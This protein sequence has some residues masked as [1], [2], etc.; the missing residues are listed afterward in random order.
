MP[1]TSGSGLADILPLTPLQE[2][3]FFHRLADAGGLDLYTS[4]LTLDLAGPLEPARLR[5]AGQALLDR[6]PNLR[7]AF[8]QRK[9]GAPVALIPR[10]VE[11]PWRELDL[12]GDDPDKREHELARFADEE[13]GAPFDPG[14]PPLVRFALVR[15]DADRHTLVVT[16]HHILLDGWSMPL[17]VQ[18]LCDL[19]AAGGDAGALPAPVPFRAHLEWL[20][21]QDRTAAVEEWRTVLAGVP[22]PTLVRPEG[23]GRPA[24]R[25]P[26]TVTRRLDAATTARLTAVAREHGATVSTVIQL[27]WGLTVATLTGRTDVVFGTTVAGRSPEVEGVERIL[28]LCINTVPVRVSL[29]PAG[30][31][32]EN[33]TA[34]QRTQTALLDHQHLGLPEI[35]RAAGTGELFDTMTVVE[36]WPETAPA[37]EVGGVRLTGMTCR[38]ATHYPLDLVARPDR[39]LELRVHHR[40]DLVDAGTAERVADWLV[41]ALR[42][43]AIEPDRTPA[44][45]DL[46]AAA[47]RTRVLTDWND[48]AVAPADPDATLT[49]RLAAQVVRT[50]DALAVVADSR[51]LT[52]RQLHDEAGRLAG[53]LAERGVGPESVVA[54]SVPRSAELMIALLA[55]ELA[56]AAYLPVEVDLPAARRRDLVTDARPVI[57]LT[58]RAGLDEPEALGDLDWIVLDD[59]ATAAELATRVV[60][61]PREPHPDGAAY[62][63]YTSGSTGRPK[64]VAVSH[65]AIVNRLDWMQSAMPLTGD[66][67]VLQKTPAGFDVS[68]WE[69]FW[70]LCEGAAVVFARPGGHADPAYLRELIAA[71]RVTTLHF[72]P[73]MLAAFLASDDGASAAGPDWPATLRRCVCSGEALST[74]LAQRWL[75]RTGVELHNL[76]GPT[77][78]AVD[79]TAWTC[80]PGAELPTAPGVPIGRPVW[81]TQVRVLDAWLRP[82]PVGVPGELYL[83]GVQLARGYAGRPGLTSER[84][85]ADP[86]GAPGERLYRTG[87]LV[88]WRHDG[89]LT[90]LGRTDHQVKIRGQRVEPGELEAALLARPDVA[91]AAAVPRTDGPGGTYLCAYVVPATGAELDP[92]A[93][94]AE[95]TATLPAGLVPGAVV[96][97]DALP[98]TAN[99]KLD[100]AGLPAPER[101]RGERRE[102]RTAAE[103]ALCEVFAAVLRLDEVG[104]D[105]DFFFLGGDSIISISLVAQARRRGIDLT[106]RQIFEL[107]TPAALAATVPAQAATDGTPD[108][109]PVALPAGDPDGV[110]N[111]PL[112]PVVHWLRERGGP[113]G[114]FSQSVLVHTPAG[115]DAARLE[116]ALQVLFDRHDALRLRLTRP[117]PQLWSLAAEPTGR[118]RA[119][120]VLRRVDART[121]DADALRAA[122]AAET[123]AAADRLDPEAGE[124]VA[125]VWFDR[126]A[127]AGRL[128]LVV[129]HLAVDGVS[130]RILLPDLAAAWAGEPLDA[131]PT[132]LRTWARRLADEAASPA[133][134][135]ELEH[136]TATTAPGARLVPAE[137]SAAELP[138]A[139]ANWTQADTARTITRLPVAD[140]AALL[141]AVPAAARSG[142]ANVLLVAF[143]RAVDRWRAEAGRATGPVLVDVEGHGR[144]ASALGAAE[145]DLS[146]TVGWLTTVHPLRIETGGDSL[147]G[148]V[149]RVKETVR[150]VPAAGLGHGLLR[151]VNPQSAPLLAAGERA[152]VLFNYLGRMPAADRT[153]TPWTPA[154]EAGVLGAAADP[155]QPVPYVLTLDALTEDGPDGPQLA[156]TWTFVPDALS[157]AD[158]DALSAHFAAAVA[159]LREWAAAGNTALTPADLPAVTLRQDEIDR[160][161]AFHR[162][163]TPGSTV[164]DIWPLS[165]L[166]EGLFFLASFDAGRR[167]IYTVQDHFDLDTTVDVERLRTALAALLARTPVLRAGFTNDGLAAPVQF[168]ASVVEP[169]LDVV[170]LR[171][172][173][174]DVEADRLAAVMAAD[175]ARRFDVTSPPLLAVTVVLRDGN[176]SR[177]VLSH[178]LLLWDGWSA[179]LLFA[180][181]FELYASGGDAAGLPR[182]GSYR[183]YLSWLREQDAE[184]S[185]A[186]WRDALAELDSP[187]LVHP[188]LGEA[189][190]VPPGIR[191]ITLD[192]AASDAIR[193]AARAAGVTLNTLVSAAWGLVLSGL[194]GSGDVVFGTTVSG[195]PPAVPDVETVI[196]LF[197]NTVPARVRIDPAETVTDL[198]GRLH[199]E[200]S[201]VLGHDW[202]GLARIQRESGHPQLFDTLSVMQNFL[203][204]DAD[205]EAFRR[206]HG[207]T[208]VGYADATHYPLTLVVTPTTEL[209]LGLYH[210][211]D[212]VTEAAAQAVLDRFA[213]VLEVLVADPG[214]RVGE[215]DTLTATER[216]QVLVEWNDTAADAGT[217]SISELLA[218][219]AALCPDAVALVTADGSWTYAELEA[220]VNRIARALLARGAGPER[221]VALALPRAADMVAALF[222]VLRTG[223]A[224]LPI[225]ADTPA[226]RVAF[227]LADAEP[228]CVLTTAARDGQLP[229]D[230]PEQVR[231]DDPATAAA[232]GAL[233]AEPLADAERPGFAPGVPHRLEHPAY[234]I[235]TSG[236][237]GL[238]KGVITPYRGLTNMQLN[239]RQHIFDPVVAQAGGRRLRI[240]HTVSF[241]FDMSWEELLWLVE[242]H[243]VHVCDEDLRRD[244]E[245]LVAYCAAHAVDVVNVTP[246]YAAQLFE[247]GLLDGPH[248][249]P[250]VLLGGE[251]VPEHVWSRLL[252]TPGVTGYNLYGPTEYTINTLG[253]GTDDSTTPTVGRPIRNTVAYVLD[254]RLRPVPPGVAGELYITGVGLARGYLKRA[255]LTAERFVADPFGEPGAR[256]YRTGDLVRWRSDGLLDFVGRAD[257]QVKIR[258]YRV[259]PGEVAAALAAHPEVVDAAVI[260][261]PAGDGTGSSRLVGYVVPAPAVGDSRDAAESAH[262]EQWQQIYDAEYTEI[263]TA[264]FTTDF[265][266]WDSS[267]TGA[268]IPF[269]E[270]SEWRDATL[271]R[272]RS[273]GARRVL[274]VGVGSGLLLSGLARDVDEYWATDFSAPV[275][276]KLT[277]DVATDPELAAR[278]RLE[279]RPAEHTAGLPRGH[280]DAVV[281]NS[282]VQYFPSAE[283]LAEV[284]TGLAELLAPGGTLFVG[285]VRDL[286]SLRAFHAAIAV[287]QTDPGVGPAQLEAQIDRRVAL[288]KELVLH[289]AW[290]ADLAERTPT[291]AGAD[292]RLKAGR[293]HNELTRH[294]YDVLLHAAGGPEPVAVDTVPG[295]V[296][297]ADLENPRLSGELAALESLT[298][299]STAARAALRSAPTGTEPDDVV[300]AGYRTLCVPGSEPDRYEAV[301]VPTDAPVRLT[302][303]CRA[304]PVGELANAPAAARAAAD[305]LVRLRGFLKESMPDYMVPS[306]LVPLPALPLTVN[307]KLDRRALPAPEPVATTAGRPP[308]TPVEETLCALFAEVL[309]LE[310]VGATD[311]FF[312]AGG[313]SLL[314]TR[315]ISRARSELGTDLA[316]RDLFE[317]PTAEE[318]ARRV[319]ATRGPARAALV[320]GPRPERVPLSAAQRRLWLVDRLAGPSAAYNFPLVFR[321]TGAL[322]TD[323]LRAAVVDVMTRHE[324]L[325]TLF[326]ED[327]GEPY[328]DVLDAAVAAA[329]FTRSCFEVVPVAEEAIED[330]VAERVRAPFRLG[331][332]LPVRVSVLTVAPDD[333][334]V[335]IV[336]HH[337]TTDEWSDRPFLA[338]LDT[339]YRARVAG[340]DPRLPALPV[341]YA[342]YTLWQDRLLGDAADPDSLMARQ[343]EYWTATLAGSPVELRLPTDRPRPAE[344]SGAGGL[345]R[346]E[347]P[348]ETAAGLR[349]LAAAS[350][351][352]MFMTLHAAFA[353]LLTRLGAGEDLPIGVPV[354]GRADGALDDL[355][356]FFVNTVVL[357]T[358][359]SGDPSFAD[360]LGRVRETGLAA[361]DAA[362]VPFERVVE[363]VNPPRVPGRNPLFGVLIG[364]HARSGD[365]ADLLGLPTRWLDPALGTA[366]FDLAVDVVDPGTGAADALLLKFEYSRDLFDGATVAGL[367]DRMLRLLAA[368]AA[369]P[370]RP[371]SR[372][373]LLAPGEP[374]ELLA[375]GV[376]PELAVPELT[377]AQ[378]LAVQA[379]RT[380]DRLALVAG[381]E[382]LTFA[383]LTGRAGGVAAL[384]TEHG[385]RPGDLVALALPRTATVPAIFGVLAAGAAYLPVDANQPPARL[386]QMFAEA[387][388]VVVLTTAELAGRLPAGV[389]SV[390]LPADAA[391]DRFAPVALPADAPAYVI[392]TSGS[393]G[394]P[395]GVVGIHRGLTNLFTAQRATV[396]DPA[397][398]ALGR[399]V[400]RASCVTSFSFDA[401]WDPLLWLVAGHELHVL[402]DESA[403]DPAA[404]VAYL[405]TERIDYLDLTPTFL[406][407]LMRAGLG[408]EGVRPAVLVVGGEATPP[409]LWDE[410]TSWPLV[411]VHDL[412][413]PTECTVDAWGRS[414]ART[415]DTIH[416]RAGA[417]ANLAI[418]ILDAGLAPVPDGVPGELYLAG[419][420]LARGYLNRPG[421]TADRFVADPFGRPG[422][423]MY[424]TGDL[425]RRRGNS[426][427]D[428]LG[429]VDGQ[430]KLRGLRIETGEIEAALRAAGAADAAVVVREDRPGDPRLVAYVV[431]RTDAPSDTPSDIQAL[432]AAAAATLPAALVPSAFVVLPALPRSVAGKVDRAAL[433]APVDHPRSALGRAPATALEAQVCAL[434]AEVLG[435]P[436]GERPGADADFF[437]LGGHSLLAMRLVA[438]LRAD[439][440]A[441]VSLRTVFDAPTPERLAAR[442]A[443]ASSATALSATVR[444][445]LT[446]VPAGAEV[447]LAPAQHGLW[448]LDRIAGPSP[449]Y[450]I[451]IA[452]RLTGELDAAALCAAVRDLAERHEPL[453]TVVVERDGLPYQRLVP[454]EAIRVVESAIEP[455]D[456]PARLRAAALHTF[457]LET[458]PPLRAELLR[459]GPTDHV[460]ALTVH[461]IAADEWS[462][463]PLVTDLATAYAARRAGRAPE[464]ASLPARYADF[465]AWQHALLGERGTPTEFARAQTGFWRNALIGLPVELALPTD[466][467]RPPVA[468]GRG[469][470]VPVTID[471]ELAAALRALGRAHDV[472]TFMVLQAAVA[473]LLHRSGA[474]D[475]I[476]I[477]SPI[478]G[479]ADLALGDLVGYFL[480]T[481]VLRTDLSGRPSFA[482]VLRRVRETDLAA[483]EHQDLPFD[484]VVEAVNPAR[485]PSRHPLFQVMVVH[486]PAPDGDPE[487]PGLQTTRV[488]ADAAVAKFDLSFDFV[489]ERATDGGVG[490]ISGVVEYAADL[491]DE[492]TAAGLADRLLRLLRAVVADPDRPVAGIDVL[493]RG[494]RDAALAA[495][496]GRPAG[497][498]PAGALPAGGAATVPAL[499]EAQVRRDP[500]APALVVG[501]RRLTFGE[502]NAEANRLARLLVAAGAGPERPVGLVLPRTHAMT[503]IL[504]A[505]KAGA[506]Y[507]PAEPDAPATR[508]AAMFAD[509]GAVVVVTSSGVA[510]ATGE[511][512]EV[513][514]LVVDDPATVARLAS[515][516]DR[517]L[518]DADRLAPLAP[519]HPAYVIYTSGS[520][521]TPKGV[522][523]PH[524][525]V[526]NLYASHAADLHARAVAAAGRDR[527]RVGHAWSFSFDASWQPQLWLLGG[528][529]V[530]VLDDETRRDADLLVAAV[531]ERDL[532]FLEVTPSFLAQLLAAGLVRSD[533]TGTPHCPLHLLGFGGEAVPPGVWTQLRELAGTDA[534]NL[535]GP[536][537]AT[538]DSLVAFVDESPAPVV[539]RPVAGARAC[540]LDAALHPVPPGVTGE[541]YLSGAGLARGYLNR[542]G[543]TA[544]RFVADPF[545]R[546]GTRMYRT[547]DLARFDAAGRLEYRGRSDDQVKLRGYRIEPAEIEAVLGRH[548]DLAAAVVVVRPGPGGVER[549]VAY[550]VPRPG[551]AAPPAAELR[552]LAADALPDHM[553]PTVF[554]SLDALPVLPGGKLNRAALPEPPEAERIPSRPP[555]TAVEA[556]VVLVVGDLLGIDA[557]VEDDFF[558]LGGDSILAMQVVSRLRALDWKV[559]PRQ[560]LAG[561]TLDAIAAAATPSDGSDTA[562]DGTGT[563]PL[564]PTMVW[565]SEVDTPVAAI[566]QSSL[567]LT[568]VGTTKDGLRQALAAVVLHHDL[569]RARL[570]RG[571]PWTLEVPPAEQAAVRLE[572]VDAK[573]G[574]DL[575]TLVAEHARAARDRVDPDAGVM[576]AAVWFDGGPGERGRLL[577]TVHHLVMDAMSW[578]IL[579]EDLAAAAAGRDLPPV[580]TSFR[581][582]AQLL[583]AQV[584][585]QR[586]GLPVAETVRAGGDPLPLRRPLDPARDVVG[587][588]RTHCETLPTGLTTALLGP[589][590][591]AYGARV[592]DVLLAALALAVAD[593][594]DRRGGVAS[595]GDE[596]GGTTL[597]DVKG[598]GRAGDLDVSRT[599]GRFAT[600]V[601][602]LLDP[603]PVR[604]ADV[605]S[606]PAAAAAVL[607]RVRVSAQ[608]ASAVGASAPPPLEFNYLGRVDGAEDAD[609]ASAPEEA[610]A[611][612]GLDPS[613]PLAHAL[614]LGAVAEEGPDGVVLLATW[615]WPDGVLDADAVVDLAQTWFRALAALAAAA[616][617]D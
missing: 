24:D 551:A 44:G 418:R 591:A 404:V 420:G 547:G 553:V 40:L 200:R 515:A 264:V 55:V 585:H 104:V 478:T 543:L 307:G 190:P 353:A 491:F 65:R 468:T 608:A 498:L 332:E 328:Q 272:I 247:H 369:D 192:E 234:V 107:R 80:R 165:P 390:V 266:G 538:V 158:V 92:D 187:T 22:G 516:D 490:G 354:A 183:D 397:A 528:H 48:T 414:A 610:A 471:A 370:D 13:Q 582:H 217:E 198:L 131:V 373:D 42:S 204:D 483:Y 350:G 314:A 215:L 302:G 126:G 258:G 176:R 101:A 573:G 57:G 178:H 514:V 574:S 163:R 449:T 146:R 339:A 69:F 444:P 454:A 262:V 519:A 15:L 174:P 46:L 457:D 507:V 23:R 179:A 558:A 253:G 479:R 155:E 611:D 299:G 614:S 29:D 278:V 271:A 47:E 226:D 506:P 327:R 32:G 30:S 577:L 593:W 132:T 133:R 18:E 313:H 16:H 603:G 531:W 251:A 323:A 403:L 337:V 392:F 308:A 281:I 475:D 171:G 445:A 416:R 485:S 31:L 583:T 565:M 56:G 523:V 222:A 246:T 159:E 476:P 598:H 20:A 37:T 34:L 455:A 309:G 465:A 426:E 505:A 609:W 331:A 3:L 257:D 168:L 26:L 613:L 495:G 435:L 509:A 408:P 108:G 95:L 592:D 41:A 419:P 208:D 358:D 300:R 604:L 39:E 571:T 552:R 114:R 312:A 242:G 575:E 393:T 218:E 189:E 319:E 569:L 283:H 521:G 368:V 86:Y 429:R 148:A 566:Q 596:A 572:R 5:A 113:I 311:D 371:L 412:Y 428:F 141:G 361:F 436:G 421:L 151:Y 212:V 503:A 12:S 336:L 252:T 254:S 541:L 85:V 567:V 7:A 383:E 236:S 539:G 330:V 409:D 9:D 225:D 123:S 351:A 169:P 400:L 106:P 244:P 286:R 375:A 612:L 19:Y 270:M 584:P 116:T 540:V 405:G 210:R 542:A 119:A 394:T 289:P 513:P 181:L 343:L 88:A 290:F 111:V 128:L 76:Y 17:L 59:P 263:P 173:E 601:P 458:E 318:L 605:E 259:E 293:G 480:N 298:S 232:L 167:D 275:I 334:V 494:E 510:G 255:G 51:R 499:F 347:V 186:V 77:E 175:R 411:A 156:V 78:A 219:R 245:A 112:L 305:L 136:W 91:A 14:V 568:P 415:G 260:A 304:R 162:A 306:A 282:V 417:V 93:V 340:L 555:A 386:E 322:D 587:T 295:A 230:G 228:V 177:I 285:D 33:L 154:P 216:A 424:R 504:A 193:A 153:A 344:P 121:F 60:A 120:D 83:A 325:R 617:R 81:N 164:T 548:G 493:A 517:D 564:T 589:V 382:R 238:P 464:F 115:A 481:I 460:L 105:D 316:I 256:M 380:P 562:D 224:Y 96:V 4:Q 109:A 43:L 399:E 472:S 277:A 467:P 391:V 6:H 196:G 129:H 292:I 127:E 396:M 35:A 211:P 223:A 401:S 185:A 570:V 384:L 75:D 102:P 398:Q 502:L 431:G 84:F 559:T 82:A 143:G 407:E 74:E 376:G 70:A 321:L 268:P 406:R 45:L 466:R 482:D 28:G 125:A 11:L 99:G 374:A 456:L 535:Y 166:Q 333:A 520:T 98:V 267:Y 549:L 348:A 534:V 533:A 161:C 446:P 439:L 477:G 72:V 462:D 442:L 427:L 205:A 326:A 537:E 58:V 362:D 463:A 135:G 522:V 8:R 556:A 149:R 487:L 140:T 10:S 425:V 532:D 220:R 508:T 410:L 395:K 265:A 248:V 586:G 599:L 144:D 21:G 345:L 52:Y 62:L 147:E 63:I 590:P 474:G 616:P 561:R 385:V 500:A 440:G 544:D 233:S 536:T 276:A 367:A 379:E 501:E 203:G 546:P 291:L 241:S 453:R 469:G 387:A 67:R 388:P 139:A 450:N 280:F 324:S 524:A 103:Q 297:I 525:A 434:F 594:R 195:R 124:M 341:Q 437:A 488:D 261:V 287:E 79:V 194:T 597:V 363:A 615:S 422:A 209:V 239:H 197:L 560:I 606:V 349:R 90:Y 447:P 97:L 122:V 579:L 529:E 413:G 342:D 438:R 180:D 288:E 134:L 1:G 137:S 100:R 250:L 64:G 441:D 550:V 145:L 443:T 451:P 237:T 49:G 530:H 152:Q 240:A 249:P 71:E 284:L 172:L 50:P 182:R 511:W 338:D 118:V 554:V 352:S 2:G 486:L 150:A 433:P 527:L 235:Y 229:A 496:R 578:R 484:R 274:E 94:T 389:R 356:G 273:L 89:A 130:W 66:D 170:D 557:G 545:G 61:A 160:V 310:R 201:A 381:A 461:H 576:W 335:V 580:T 315:L 492:S 214:V 157:A 36:N 355:V 53:L 357:R 602:V 402:D 329:E 595:S 317:A 366:Q 138:A 459:L 199:R 87:D 432:R 346:A 563:V 68:V 279:C 473:A 526:A 359:T 512:G 202:L 54:V 423:R 294:R 231:L 377:V 581:R 117:V 207:I 38:D 191:R 497:A 448:V 365:D 600:G 27:V 213:A 588:E 73:S 452:W 25:S 360:L 430:V 184:V 301:L 372:L 489:D 320:P 269:D 378:I 607:D 110:G 142:V 303:T 188:G 206:R 364:Y 296:R 518:T 243:E 470:T 221:V 227:V